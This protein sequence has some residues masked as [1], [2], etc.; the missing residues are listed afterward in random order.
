MVVVKRTERLVLRT[1]AA[2]RQVLADQGDNIDRVFYGGFSRV[3]NDGAPGT[4]DREGSGPGPWSA[5]PGA[6]RMSE[7]PERPL[8]VPC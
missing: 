8:T 7:L 3:R 1:H 4:P 5:A 6:E 2:Q